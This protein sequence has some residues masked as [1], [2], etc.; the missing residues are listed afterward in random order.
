[1]QNPRCLPKPRKPNR[2]ELE[3]LTEW[4]SK[5]VGSQEECDQEE[6]DWHI[7]TSYIAV[8]DEY[9]TYYPGF[10]GKLMVVVWGIDPSAYQV[11]TWGNKLGA[12]GNNFGKIT[13][14]NQHPDWRE[15]EADRWD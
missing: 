9:Q 15:T 14:F 10:V 11:F 8:F 2:E 7:A 5:Q 1:M 4:Y 3:Q 12:H 6:Y 13:P